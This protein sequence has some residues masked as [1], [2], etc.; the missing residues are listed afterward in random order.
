METIRTEYLVKHFYSGFRLGGLDLRVEPGEVLGIMG[1]NGAGK[2]TLLRLLWGFMRP[3]AGTISIFGMKPHLEQM[4]VR[5]RAGYLADSP[6]WYGGLTAGQFLE[7]VASFYEGW[8]PRRVGQLLEQFEIH[9]DRRIEYLSQGMRVKLGLISA[10]G[11]RPAL[12]ILDEPTS[13]LDP[14]VRLDILEFLQKLAREEDVSI[15]LSSQISDDLDQIA[16][17]ILMLHRG[18]VVEYAAASDL[19]T[20]YKQPRLEKIFVTAVGHQRH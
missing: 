1:P 16:D 15:V 13:S 12:L 11:H 2:T 6:P 10:V 9:E 14:L 19:L 20:K 17:S 7:F 8:D 3:D 4:K 5:L 18:S